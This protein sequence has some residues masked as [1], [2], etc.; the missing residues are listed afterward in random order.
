MLH[1]HP[2][3]VFKPLIPLL[4]ILYLLPLLPHYCPLLLAVLLR[5]QLP[6]PPDTLIVLQ[7]NAG[8][9]RARSTELLL[10]LSVSRNPILA[11]LPL[12]GSLDS[13]LCVMIAPTP[14]RAFSLLMPCTLAAAS[15]FS[16]GRAYLSLNFLPPLSL[17]LIPTLI[18]LCRDQHLSKQ[19]LLTLIS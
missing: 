11:H 9:L 18:I 6:L 1:L 2:T 16:S 3:F 19:L 17:R 14:S 13:L 15:S 10:T 8:G 4:P 7:W 5:L 12:S